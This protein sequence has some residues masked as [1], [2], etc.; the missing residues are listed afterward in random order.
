[1]EDK[2]K[3]TR[4]VFI[5]C[6][7]LKKIGIDE[8]C[9]DEKTDRTTEINETVKLTKDVARKLQDAGAIKVKL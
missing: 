7:T 9:S 4:R 1:M 6:V 8:N 2:E 3:K 5:E